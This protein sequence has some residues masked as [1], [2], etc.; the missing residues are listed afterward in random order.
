MITTYIQSGPKNC[1]QSL[2]IFHVLVC[3][4]F[5]GPLCIYI[6]IY[7]YIHTHTSVS[8]LMFIVA[9]YAQNSIVKINIK[10]TPTCFDIN[11][12]SSGNLQLCW[13]KL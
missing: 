8:C 11:T 7:I 10:I 1:I 4:Y 12:P 6:Y 9:I 3:I 13:L 2:F 5:F